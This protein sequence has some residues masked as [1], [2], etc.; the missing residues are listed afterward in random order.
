MGEHE[1]ASGWLRQAAGQAVGRRLNVP[2]VRLR[3]L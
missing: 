3:R 1:V 2:R